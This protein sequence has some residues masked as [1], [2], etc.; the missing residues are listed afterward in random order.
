MSKWF[1]QCNSINAERAEKCHFCGMPS[2]WKEQIIVTKDMATLRYENKMT[3][4]DTPTDDVEQTIMDAA[5]YGAG[6]MKDGKRVD[7]Q[8]VYKTESGEQPWVDP[9]YTR[10]AEEA[11]QKWCLRLWKPEIRELCLLAYQE[12]AAY[13]RERSAKLVGALSLYA[14]DKNLV[15]VRRYIT[16]CRPSVTIDNGKLARE[17]LAAYGLSGSPVEHNK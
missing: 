3:P 5:V 6:F 12:G 17:A 4:T 13:E 11:A 10:Q 8:D 7:P 15:E 14:D 16:P 1:C 9:R 2:D